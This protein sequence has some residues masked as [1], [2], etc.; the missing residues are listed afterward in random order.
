MFTSFTTVK[1]GGFTAV[2]VQQRQTNVQKKSVMHVQSCCFAS[3]NLLLLV[4][5]VAIAV[6]VA[7]APY[8]VFRLPSSVFR[9]RSSFFVLRLR[10]S[11]FSGSSFLKKRKNEQTKTAFNIWLYKDYDNYNN[12][13]ISY[14]QLK[15]SKTRINNSLH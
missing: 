1:L 13:A 14:L 2:V 6:V 15:L 9:L 5:L 7:K 12:N 3:L 10:S 8:Q 11:V 4:V